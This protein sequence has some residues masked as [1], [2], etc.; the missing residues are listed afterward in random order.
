MVNQF[1]ETQFSKCASDIK[2]IEHGNKFKLTPHQE[3]A[4]VGSFYKKVIHSDSESQAWRM[5]TQANYQRETRQILQNQI[6]SMAHSNLNLRL[7]IKHF[8]E[9]IEAEE[10]R[11]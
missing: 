3:I 1:G 8:A 5:V 11:Q 9:A 6:E 7:K 2:Q 4:A 10:R